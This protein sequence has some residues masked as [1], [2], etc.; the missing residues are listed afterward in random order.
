M[1]GT[2]L[3]ASV[4]GDNRFRCNYE[5]SWAQI[6]HEFY[7]LRQSLLQLVYYMQTKGYNPEQFIQTT[8]RSSS[9]STNNYKKITAVAKSVESLE[10][11]M[12][13]LNK[14][15][16]QFI[17]VTQNSLFNAHKE[18]IKLQD[19]IKNWEDRNLEALLSPEIYIKV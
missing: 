4:I 1:P 19:K 9:L 13:S 15:L 2:P 18:I 16:T 8:Y 5:Q 6:S 3:Y 17:V 10:T 11:K 7:A 12:S 14:N